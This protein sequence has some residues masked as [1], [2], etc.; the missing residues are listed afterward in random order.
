MRKHAGWL[1]IALAVLCLIFLTG[2]GILVKG[3]KSQLAYVSNPPLLNCK[4]YNSNDFRGSVSAADSASTANSFSA[5]DHSTAKVSESGTISAPAANDTVNSGPI[6]GG[7]VPHHL[8]AGKMIAVFFKTLAE[9]HPDTL[10]IIAPN[11]QRIGHNSIN[12]S[13]LGWSTELGTLE[14][15]PV[16]TNWIISKTGASQDNTLMEEEHS[17]SSLIPYIKYYMPKVKIVPVLMHGNYSP[18]DSAQFGIKLAGKLTGMSRMSN[19]SGTSKTS[20]TAVIASVDFSHY[21]DAATANKM[22]EITLAA[23]KKFDVKSIGTMGNDN[24]D[25]PPSIIALLSAMKELHAASLEVTGHNNSSVIAGK[26]ADYTTSYFT[27]L[28]RRQLR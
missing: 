22:D 1:L 10:V 6:I 21:L 8:L 24:L 15:E 28:F 25:S 3:E 13:L 17:I 18:Y 7:V 19:T 20:N 12:T 4:F 26:G 2:H 16:L 11:H 23:I 9:S 27:L 14:N 5:A